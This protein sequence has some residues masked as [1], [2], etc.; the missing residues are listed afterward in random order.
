VLSLYIE[1]AGTAAAKRY[2]VR[3]PEPLLLTGFS[4]SET[5]HAIRML[6]F[7]KQRTTEEATRALLHLERD[8]SEGIYELKPAPAEDLF[9]KVAQLSNR[10]AVELGVR[11][12]DM[13]HVASALLVH[14]KRFLTFDARQGKLAKAAGLQVKP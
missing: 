10:H 3:N 5:Q 8:L 6:A 9:G 4:K 12:L 2:L 11:Y 7:R 13:L 1:D 14:A